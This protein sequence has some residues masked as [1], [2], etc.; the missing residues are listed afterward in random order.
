M[1]YTLEMNSVD[2]YKFCTYKAKSCGQHTKKTIWSC[3]SLKEAFL[4]I[5]VQCFFFSF[6]HRLISGFLSL[7]VCFDQKS[8]NTETVVKFLIIMP[9]M[10]RLIFVNV[11]I[12]LPFGEE[13]INF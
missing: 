9:K 13:N 4:T 11:D 6:W 2:A 7:Y 5:P 12:Q 10:N 3:F 1:N 8:G